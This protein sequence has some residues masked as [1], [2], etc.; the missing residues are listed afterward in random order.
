MKPSPQL[1]DLEAAILSHDESLSAA[2]P[3][4]PTA[5]PAAPPTVP[6]PRRTASGR[7]L[8]PPRDVRYAQSGDVS[9]AYQVVGSG[10]IDLVFVPGFISH[11]ELFWEEPATT[12]FFRRLAS[13]SRLILHD[14]REQGLSDR[15]GRPPTLES[16][17]DDVRAVMD[18]AGSERAALFGISEGGPLS[19]MLAAN[20]PER[21]S[22]LV[23]YGTYA[24]MM[25]APD[26]PIGTAPEVMDGWQQ[27]LLKEWG[28]AP[29]LKRFAPT[30]VDDARFRDWWSRLLRSG[31]SPRGATSL[32]EM[33]R[34][35][36]VRHLLGTIAQ[37]S[38]V[39][40]RGGDELA[41]VEWGRE[42]TRGI[43]GSRYVEL[44]GTDH[45][46]MAG[47]QDELLDEVEEFLTGGRLDREP[48]RV[49]QTVL[50]VH[51]VG[52]AERAATRVR[53]QLDRHR[54]R[55]VKTLGDGT[56]AAFDSPAG[57]IRCAVAIRDELHELGLELRAGVHTGECEIV[58]G[59]LAGLAV[60]IGAQVG[61]E[62]APGE[63]LASGT[64]KDLVVGS[65]IAFAERGTREL[66]GVPGT[67]PLFA[68]A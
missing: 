41:P 5:A 43:P 10:D 53:R 11:M 52:S 49:L 4:A 58:D 64:V 45:L 8:G 61:A 17:I 26:Y 62:A 32:F 47:D 16:S 51:I 21:V 60:H 63:V 54:G 14:K 9:I 2:A 6:P 13:F 57:A 55:M 19:I 67:W 12:R 28:A 27:N 39:L 15:L 29:M 59:D 1:R 33:H 56:L 66:Q 48:E 42:L 35:T 44:S 22:A 50:F 18:A 46:W 34:S 68:V 31:T 25:E 7:Y 38:L 36:D 37:P 20:E 24:R 40:H 30:L 65:G 3:A 23:L